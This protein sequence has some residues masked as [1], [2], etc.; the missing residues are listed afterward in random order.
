MEWCLGFMLIWVGNLEGPGDRTRITWLESILL[1][2]LIPIVF[3]GRAAIIILNYLKNVE[4]GLLVNTIKDIDLVKDNLTRQMELWFW[5]IFWKTIWWRPVITMWYS[6]LKFSELLF[7][8]TFG[9]PIVFYVF[10]KSV[11][12]FGPENVPKRSLAEIIKNPVPPECEV[13]P[14]KK[15]T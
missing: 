3:L 11:Y 6:M 14:I 9:V 7:Y 15:S 2:L 1:T 8:A 4:I 5:L 10:F 12:E 13:N